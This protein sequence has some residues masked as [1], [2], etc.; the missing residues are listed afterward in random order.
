MAPLNRRL[1]FLGL[2]SQIIY[3]L[4]IRGFPRQTVHFDGAACPIEPS[5]KEDSA[6]DRL[7]AEADSGRRFE[8][9]V[10]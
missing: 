7:F 6:A 2:Y 8:M 3:N 5:F 10:G 1:G 4:L 9:L